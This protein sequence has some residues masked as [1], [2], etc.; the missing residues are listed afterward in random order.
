MEI[1]WKIKEISTLFLPSLISRFLTLRPSSSVCCGDWMQPPWQCVVAAVTAALVLLTGPHAV[2]GH[3]PASSVT[4][5]TGS[6][7]PVPPPPP[8]WSECTDLALASLHPPV[9]HS[10]GDAVEDGAPSTAGE[11]GSPGHIAQTRARLTSLAAAAC[12][13]TP[14]PTLVFTTVGGLGD[15]LKGMVTAFYVALLTHADFQVSWTAP[16]PIAP[17]FEM[18]PELMWGKRKSLMLKNGN[19]EHES[20]TRLAIPGANT[21]EVVDVYRFFTDLASDFVAGLAP[22]ANSTFTVLRTNADSWLE[23]VRRPSLRRAAAM[24]GLTDLSRRDLFVLAVQTLLRRPSHA[25]VEAAT[26]DLPH[27]LQ[28]AVAKNLAIG[29]GGGLVD[30]RDTD[31]RKFPVGSAARPPRRRGVTTL[32]PLHRTGLD[33]APSNAS[34]GEDHPHP[35]PAFIGVQIRTGGV[36]E[37]WSDS[38]HRH[39]VESARCFAG[40]AKKWC[41]EIYNGICVVFLT[42][43]S[44]AAARAFVDALAGTDV[45]IIQTSG[46]ILH[47]DRGVPATSRPA[48]DPMGCGP[49]DPWL[50]TYAD[51]AVLSQADLLLTS[52]SGYGQTAAWAGGVPHVRQLRK[53]GACE[54][55]RLDDCADCQD[56]LQ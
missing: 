21:V 14:Q 33:P 30:T 35:V 16:S 24:Y 41:L 51:W 31:R 38:D 7:A 28:A 9:R 34:L 47:T 25:V 19:T 3:Q 11:P 5:E 6:A 39:P 2:T 44:R 1:I 36:G 20:A 37:A 12:G 4:G 23:V 56:K 13:G 18:E 40:E 27:P 10:L 50:K 53:G 54:W 42:A 43:D 26:S 46:P 49:A 45:A 29:F 22:P 8:S 55:T 48:A 52:H 17:Y 15:R 32:G